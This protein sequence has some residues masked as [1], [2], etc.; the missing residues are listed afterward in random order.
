M[1]ESIADKVER[2]CELENNSVWGL[3]YI[4]V[5]RETHVSRMISLKNLCLLINDMM[6]GIIDISFQDF[7]AN[8]TVVLLLNK[9]T[10]DKIIAL[11]SLDHLFSNI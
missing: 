6:D 3:Y 10:Y 4:V 2:M 7:V 9:E 1:E 8:N 11:Q 5:C